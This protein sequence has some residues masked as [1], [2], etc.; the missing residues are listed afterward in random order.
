[1]KI[2]TLTSGFSLP[3]IGFGT[4]TMWGKMQ[5]EE[6]YD[7]SEDVEAI[8][9][10]IDNWITH[11]DTAELYADWYS[12]EILAEAIQ[13]YDRSKLIIASKV[14]WSNCSYDDVINCCEASLKRSWVE[15]FDLYYIHWRED[16]IDL[17][18]TIKALDYLKD[19]WKIK[20]ITVCNFGLESLKEAQSYTKN[21]IVAN[22]VHY[23]LSCRESEISGLLKYCQE[24]DIMIIAWRPLEY[25]NLIHESEKF[26]ETFTQKYSK[27][28]TQIALNWLISQKNVVTIFKSVNPQHIDENIAASAWNMEENDIENIRTNYPEQ[29]QISAAVPLG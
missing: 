21:K 22:Q 3:E 10:A 14:K 1:M 7:H 17:K 15:Y 16:N 13:G 12:E 26:L 25:G 5:R 27:T 4:W 6:N 28:T 8:K 18:E 11:F 19:Q 24:N 29:V 9:Y 20:E 23:N 2:K